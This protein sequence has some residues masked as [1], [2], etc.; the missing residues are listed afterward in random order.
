MQDGTS[1][2]VALTAGAWADE[3]SLSHWV[4]RRSPKEWSER[5]PDLSPCDFFL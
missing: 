5:S 4:G 3:H 1:P 2:Y